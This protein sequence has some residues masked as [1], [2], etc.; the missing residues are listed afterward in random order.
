VLPAAAANR[1]AVLV[2]RPYS[3]AG[4]FDRVKGRPL[5]AIAAEIGATTWAQFALKWIV[6]HPAVTCAIPGTND[7]KHM[8]DN[9]EAGI[10]TMPD[11]AMRAKMA[12][13]FESA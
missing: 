1:V 11:A 12:K 4:L 7:P 2:N 6:S 10:G 3:R 8:L 13:E 9:I 5:P